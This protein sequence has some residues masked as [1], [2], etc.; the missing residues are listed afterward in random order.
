MLKVVNTN[1]CMRLAATC[2]LCAA[3]GGG[4]AMSAL[5]E[6]YP[7]QMLYAEL[8]TGGLAWRIL[9]SGRGR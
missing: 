8:S 7:P 1:P 4:A 3:D 9:W 6:K 2:A 5:G